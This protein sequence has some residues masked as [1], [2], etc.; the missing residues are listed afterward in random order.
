MQ[1]ED[2]WHETHCVEVLLYLIVDMFVFQ[3]LHRNEMICSRSS[4][5]GTGAAVV[6]EPWA[7]ML[8]MVVLMQSLPLGSLMA[9]QRVFGRFLYTQ[10]ELP[11][12]MHQ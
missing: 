2:G 9:L 7:S 6:F 10:I 5:G 3:S 4:A 8:I 11:H 12:R 1:Y